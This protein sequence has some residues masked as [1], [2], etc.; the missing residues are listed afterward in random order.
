[1]IKLKGNN[2]KKIVY[3]TWILK[4]NR[5]TKDKK[6][7]TGKIKTYHS[8]FTSFPQELYQFFEIKENTIYLIKDSTKTDEIILTDEKPEIPVTYQKVKLVA[9]RKNENKIPTTT[10]TLSRKLFSNL[11]N[12]KEVVFTLYPTSKDIYRNK[13]GVISIKTI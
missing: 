7:K 6:I 13:I 10:F 2:K 8:F 4:I 1:M 9:R 12:S 5:Y 11:N 3:T